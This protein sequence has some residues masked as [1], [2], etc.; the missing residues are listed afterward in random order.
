[1]ELPNQ[2][3]VAI[4]VPVYNKGVFLDE[5]IDS[6]FSNVTNL[7]FEVCIV[8]DA[9]TDDSEKYI[10]KWSER[11]VK[12]ITHKKNLGPSATRNTGIRNTTSP[13]II[14][15][16]ADDTLEPNYIEETF[17]TLT[18][19]KVDIVY[20]N[21]NRF[22]MTTQKLVYPEFDI[23]FLRKQNF[24]HC[25]ALYKRIVWETLGGYDEGM[26]LG[27]EDYDFWLRAG[28]HN[29]KFKKCDTTWI[30]WRLH[31]NNLTEK[32][33]TVCKQI[34]KYLKV[35]HGDWYLGGKKE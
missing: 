13:Y 28:K 30:N 21:V 6:I 18:R 12:I 11:Q 35:K 31:N 10:S 33:N 1:M 20:T 15:L 26:L 25:A 2:T 14:C 16:D 8:N 7:G 23:T 4:I 19:E 27:L 17:K 29:F 9:S 32:T 24:I 5:C 22:G 34:R 3:S